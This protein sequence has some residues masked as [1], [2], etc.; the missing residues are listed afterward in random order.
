MLACP[1]RL[2]G[3]KFCQ[4]VTIGTFVAK[5]CFSIQHKLTLIVRKDLPMRKGKV[6]AQCAHA[7]V[8]AFKNSPAASKSLWSLQG[9]PKIVVGCSGEDELLDLYH[10]AQSS[11]L[12][13]TLIK[14][15]G[16]TQLTPGTYTVLAVGPGPSDKVDSVTGH[17]KLL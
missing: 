2:S 3:Q 8:R 13:A 12:L 5:D 6:A 10:R 17:L 15:A 9:E 16:K 1:G 11:E 4:N 7:A 14:D